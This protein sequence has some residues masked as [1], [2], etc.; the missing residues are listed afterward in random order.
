VNCIGSP[1]YYLAKHL[2]EMQSPIVGLSKY[3]IR[4]SEDFMQE[5]HN[6][7]LHS[8]YILVSFDVVSL[9]TN[10]PLKDTLQLLG[11]RS[12][13][14]TINMFQ[15]A[16]ISTYFLYNGQFYD[17]MDRVA[18]GSPTALVVANFYMEHFEQQ[19]LVQLCF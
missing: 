6:I 5:L 4:N 3:H 18:M 12:D 8:T 13:T 17:Q 1:T 9:F 19:V 7:N 11:Q 14:S 10:V 15:Q 16:L 2:A